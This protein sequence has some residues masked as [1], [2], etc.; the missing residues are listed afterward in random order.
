[1][2]CGSRFSEFPNLGDD[3]S[4]GDAAH[5]PLGHSSS[6]A[7]SQPEVGRRDGAPS[8]G[9]A[10]DKMVDVANETPRSEVD[11]ADAGGREDDAATVGVSQAVAYQINVAHTGEQPGD[12]PRL[13]LLRRWAH[14]F[15]AGRVSYPLVAGGHVFVTVGSNS[16][17]GSSLFALDELTGS[18][19]WGPVSLGGTYYWSNAAYDNDLIFAVNFDGK[20]GAFDAATGKPAWLVQL[21]GQYAFSSPPTALGG[22][23]YVGG[24]GSG[25]TLYAVNEANGVVRWKAPVENGDD[26]SP[27]LSS[28]AVYVSYA[29]NQAYGFAAAT[30]SPLWHHS[31]DCEGGGGKTVALIGNSVYTRDFEGDLIL[32]AANG[33]ATGS[34]HSGPIPAASGGVVFTVSAGIVSAQAIGS[35]T[36]KWTAGDGTVV[37]APIVSGDYVVF[38]SSS[39]LLTVVAASTGSVVSSDQLGGALQGPDEQNVTGPLTGLAAANNLIFVPLGGSLV[40]Y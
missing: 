22:T 34:F 38:G 32:G 35:S 19:A 31:S 37:T 23:V 17:Y 16:G 29:C 8:D 33:I 28:S 10:P 27:A 26:S 18:V 30:G 21:P 2:A 40:A 25:G 5:A 3:V 13:P 11:A 36:P 1:M 15:G 20:L 4:I 9:R 24:A 14:D 7:S 6:E 12:V 39:G